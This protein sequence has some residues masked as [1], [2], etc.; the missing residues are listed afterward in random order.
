M[1][2]PTKV[3]PR[4]RRSLLIVLD[5]AVCAGTSS[6]FVHAFR[7]GRPS[8]NRQ[9][10]RSKL[11]NSSCTARNARALLMAD[12]IFSRLRMIPSSASR[13]STSRGP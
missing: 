5:T 4:F 11:P 10:K 1:V 12:P 3:K 9:T 2:G 6:S 7:V 13:R 8:T